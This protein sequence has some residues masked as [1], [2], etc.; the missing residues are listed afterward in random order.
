MIIYLEVQEYRAVHAVE[1]FH[2]SLSLALDLVTLLNYTDEKIRYVCQYIEVRRMSAR[3]SGIWLAAQGV[4]TLIRM[5]IWMKDPTCDN[6]AFEGV[7]G[8]HLDARLWNTKSSS[9]SFSDM[10]L[11]L[12]WNAQ[13]KRT[14][15]GKFNAWQYI[16]GLN[17]DF[18]MPVWAAEALQNSS[19]C[20]HDL[21]TVP[22][23]I[24]AGLRDNEA[25]PLSI[26]TKAKNF[27]D[28]PGWLFMSWIS[29][30]GRPDGS[31][32]GSLLPPDMKIHGFSCR[33]ILDEH[34]KCHV[35][36]FW[37]TGVRISAQIYTTQIFGNLKYDNT[38]LIYISRTRVDDSTKS[39]SYVQRQIDKLL[40][41]YKIFVKRV[42]DRTT[43]A[44]TSEGESDVHLAPFTGWR[45]AVPLDKTLEAVM[46]SKNCESL[47]F[48]EFLGGLF[49][50]AD[51][52]F[53]KQAKEDWIRN[54]IIYTM[55]LMW[56]DLIK[57]LRYAPRNKEQ[58]LHAAFDV[59]ET[60]EISP[61]E[62]GRG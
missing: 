3:N 29:I 13:L 1:L 33:V 4:F 62:G 44:T 6:H 36:P 61:P 12:I 19:T 39:L 5:A 59:I 21:F 34:G 15:H 32:D 42:D 53:P 11:G 31:P 56:K 16:F 54:N 28:M 20:L 7:D 57:I 55:D 58:E 27:W 30:H 47:G 10:Q 43:H 22:M 40:R 35:L 24:H 46:W 60:M 45:S 8:P 23:S 50:E 2:L 52:L 9:P 26:L 38:T 14:Y 37:V 41:F 51:R 49:P 25:E 48:L 17:R 18:S